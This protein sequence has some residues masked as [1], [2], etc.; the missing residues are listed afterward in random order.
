M[1]GTFLGL[2]R[3][4]IPFFVPRLS[5]DRT[6]DQY[7]IGT[8]FADI[9]LGLV[10]YVLAMVVVAIGVG[11]GLLALL[12]VRRSLAVALLGPALLFGLAL[13]GSAAGLTVFGPSAL[14]V[15]AAALAYALAGLLLARP[16]G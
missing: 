14:P 2:R 11:W 8:A 15:A 3:L 10:L 6:H 16:A 13:A 4:R 7:C 1:A 5:C 9:L 12:R